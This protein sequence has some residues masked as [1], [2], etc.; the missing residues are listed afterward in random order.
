MM[1]ASDETRKRCSEPS[2][3][4]VIAIQPANATAA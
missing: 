3:V 2:S 4:S 1:N